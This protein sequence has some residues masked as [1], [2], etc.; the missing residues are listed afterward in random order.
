MVFTIVWT[1][2]LQGP[3]MAKALL[4]AILQL[5]PRILHELQLRQ[6]RQ[7]YLLEGPCFL[8]EEW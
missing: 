6:Q 3:E 4:V 8:R 5:A 1:R 7:G 2:T